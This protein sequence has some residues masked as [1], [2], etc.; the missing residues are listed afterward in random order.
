M[1]RNSQ[2]DRTPK[3]ALPLEERLDG[4]G[5]LKSKQALASEYSLDK[6]K[7]K[8]LPPVDDPSQW[9]MAAGDFPYHTANKPLL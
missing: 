4:Q 6:G 1:T 7:N 8:P 3:S 9:Y 5:D 2:A